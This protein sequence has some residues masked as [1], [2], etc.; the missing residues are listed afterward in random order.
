M[1]KFTSPSIEVIEF[2]TTDIILTSGGG[3]NDGGPEGDYTNGG[4]SGEWA[5][6]TSIF[7]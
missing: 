5:T 3:L 6:P 1:K 2:K 7:N 4:A